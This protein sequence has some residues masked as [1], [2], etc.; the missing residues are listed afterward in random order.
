MGAEVVKIEEP[1]QGDYAR[2]MP[3][4]IDGMSAMF[5][6]LNRGKKSLTLDLRA[7]VARDAVHRL[8]PRFDV[9]LESFRP[10]VMDRLGLGYEAL[11]ALNPRLIYCAISGYGQTGP[12]R[13]RAGHDMNYLALAGVV[14]ATGPKQGPPVSSPV[15]IA[16]I[17]G[18]AYPAAVSILA[19]LYQRE[20]T[21]RGQ[22]LDISMTDG[23]LSMMMPVLTGHLADGSGASPG[24]LMLSGGLVNYQAYLTKDGRVMTLGALEPRF[25]LRFLELAGRPDLV[26]LIN[27]RGEQLEAARAEVARLLASRTR[28]EWIALLEDE[29]VCCEPALDADEVVHHPLHM[30][31]GMIREI[32]RPGAEPA[33]TVMTPLPFGREE[34]LGGRAE[35]VPPLPPAPALG[36]HGAGVLAAFGFTETEIDRLRSEGGLS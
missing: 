21:G 19:A 16:D 31:R 26:P 24:D 10:G 5:M 33:Q 30:A 13:L 25:W 28:D 22:S 14:G 1:G 17:A 11:S 36:E 27:A 12:M 15:Q 23:A 20:R 3:P 2:W 18:G 29:D 9:V 35:E 8:V 4:L 34:I 6:A 32:E 7:A